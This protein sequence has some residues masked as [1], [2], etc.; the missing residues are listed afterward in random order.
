MK[1]LSFNQETI[2][3]PILFL[4]FD[5][6]ELNLSNSWNIYNMNY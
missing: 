5:K 4:C 1:L 3:F 6:N 2:Q